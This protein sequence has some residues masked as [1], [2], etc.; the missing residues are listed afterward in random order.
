MR[1]YDVFNK[2]DT[3]EVSEIGQKEARES[4]GFPILQMGIIEDVFQMEAKKRNV[5]E[6]LEM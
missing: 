1:Q 4:I 2:L 3:Q 6:R 5:Q